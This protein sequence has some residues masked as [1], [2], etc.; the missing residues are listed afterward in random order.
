M[1]YPGSSLNDYFSYELVEKVID[2]IEQND[3][4]DVDEV[5]KLDKN[6]KLAIKKF[7]AYKILKKKTKK[8]LDLL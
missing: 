4:G 1:G 6:L 8:E 3:V 5:K 2:Q 7:A